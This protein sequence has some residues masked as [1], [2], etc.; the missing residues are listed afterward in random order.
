MALNQTYETLS[1]SELK[2]LFGNGEDPMDPMAG[3]GESPFVAGKGFSQGG[4]LWCDLFL[5][6]YPLVDPAS[7]VH[8]RSSIYIIC[9]R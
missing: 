9:C 7:L 5:I 2:Q 8:W 3:Q 4:H 1:N 6:Y